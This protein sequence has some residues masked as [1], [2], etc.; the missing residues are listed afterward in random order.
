MHRLLTGP[1]SVERLTMPI[2]GLPDHL[3][4]CR[5]VQLSDLHYDGLRLSDRM[6]LQAIARSNA[7]APD[8]VVLTGDLVTDDPTPIHQLTAYL[9]QLKSRLGTYAVLG[10]HDIYYPHSRDE[11]IDALTRA[12]I[13]VLWNQ[14]AYPFGQGLALVGLADYWSR[15]FE[16]GP[17]MAQVDESVPRLVLSHNPDTAA[18]LAAW[19]VDLQLSGHTHGGQIVLP[20]LGPF[21]SWYLK[22]R[23]FVPRSIRP[24]M[25]Y[26]KED[27]YKVLKH[28]E[29][30][31]GLHQVGANWL[32][33][34]RGLGTF[35]PGRLL[36]PPE[37]T[38][39]TL[40]S[41]VMPEPVLAKRDRR[42]RFRSSRP[43]MAAARWQ[44][45]N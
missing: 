44:G 5:L 38:V 3:T 23:R 45:E 9:A 11:V 16:P 2:A 26:M 41:R 27:C 39:I 32:Y 21:P 36:C 24:W 33:V 35:P 20:G 18:Y 4:G 14:V 19:R 8:L 30:A 10:N 12:G 34:N 15:E 28:W 13:H 37:L 7:L 17:V 40:Q 31:Q 22:V 6:L 42:G 25:P 43:E 29:W 1:L